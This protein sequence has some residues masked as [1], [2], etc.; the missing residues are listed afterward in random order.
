[1]N[2]A[3][4]TWMTPAPQRVS[5]QSDPAYIG[6]ALEDTTKPKGLTHTCRLEQDLGRSAYAI[7]VFCS[8]TLLAPLE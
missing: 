6:S 1:M 5:G 2:I 8:R 3:F 4:K 7:D